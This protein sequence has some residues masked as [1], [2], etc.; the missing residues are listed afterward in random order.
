MAFITPSVR[1]ATLTEIAP[2]AAAFLVAS[3]LAVWIVESTT[4]FGTHADKV[5][6]YR[7]LYH[8]RRRD[9]SGIAWHIICSIG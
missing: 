4:E 7:L 2:V 1:T 5:R 9:R 3:R 8:N 6:F